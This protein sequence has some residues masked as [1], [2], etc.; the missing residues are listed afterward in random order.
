MRTKNNLRFPALAALLLLLTIGQSLSASHFDSIFDNRVKNRFAESLLHKSALNQPYAY[1]P[2]EDGFFHRF[3]SFKE[4]GESFVE[5]FDI[6]SPRRALFSYRH[7]DLVADFNIYAGY[8]SNIHEDDSYGFLYKGW[9]INAIALKKLQLHTDWY[10][11][12]FYGDPDLA[13]THL[14]LNSWNTTEDR[15]ITTDNMRGEFAYVAEK[16]K[17]AIGRNTFRV[18]NSLSGSII[19]NDSTN[20]YGYLL[21][22][23]KLGDFSFALMHGSI[24]ADSVKALTGSHFYDDKAYPDKFI[25]LH[26]LNWQAG[27]NTELFLGESVIYG[28]RGM[29]VNYLLPNAFWR[30]TEHNLKDRD[31]MMLYGGVNQRLPLDML[32]YFQIAVDEFSYGKIFSSWWGNKYA[33][34]GGLE[35]PLSFADFAVELSAVRPYTYAHYMNHT[36]YSHDGKGLGYPK[37]SNIVD[38]T[39]QAN[40]PIKKYA[41]WTCRLSL[42]RS[43]S[44]GSS[45]KDNYHDIFAGQIQTAEAH[46]FDGVVTDEITLQNSIYI[47]LMAHHRFLI[48]HE[49]KKNEELSHRAFAAWQ[50]FY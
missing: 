10:S 19:L 40:V 45:W 11:G 27:K 44:E 36:M 42:S 7:P 2:A 49:M 23:F 25:S 39:L 48:G 31:N 37:G 12:R 46:W 34:Q 41:D 47:P 28:D 43:G 16:T 18:G 13:R 29:D 8:E 24:M 9:E 20:D 1:V 15:T 35:L 21:G 5:A 26:Q 6:G 4:F 32:L 3:P 14:L 33:L 17:L 30:A 38:L 50:F 22:E